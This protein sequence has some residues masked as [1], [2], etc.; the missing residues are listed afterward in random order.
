VKWSSEGERR[1]RNKLQRYTSPAFFTEEREDG[2]RPTRLINIALCAMPA[3]LE[4]EP[5]IA[6]TDPALFASA[7]AYAKSSANSQIMKPK[8]K[9]PAK[10]AVK[11]S[12]SPEEAKKAVDLITSEKPSPALDFVIA[13]LASAAAGGESVTEPEPDDGSGVPEL[14]DPAPVE[15]PA[16]KDEAKALALTML[17][18]LTGIAKPEDAIARFR[19]LSERMTKLAEDEAATELNQ[20]R[21]LLAKLVVLGYE[22]PASAWEGKPEDRKPKARHLAETIPEMKARVADLETRPIAGHQAPHKEASGTGGKVITLS[23]GRE[24]SLTQSEV[25]ACVEAGAKLED[26]AANKATR[27]AARAT[28]VRK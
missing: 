21:D 19:Q 6:A 14:S 27:E 3:T 26:F 4:N 10:S 5:L 12:L 25:G 18:E 8:L 24:V 22:T 13:L 17:A 23:D 11:L 2:E 20:R 28:R 7:L 9:K 1:L 16:K 15:D